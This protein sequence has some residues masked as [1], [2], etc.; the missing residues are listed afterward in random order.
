MC[1]ITTPL[2]LGTMVVYKLSGRRAVD[3]P[4]DVKRVLGATY[5]C[6]R[7][8]AFCQVAI[9]D[10]FVTSREFQRQYP[11]ALDVEYRPGI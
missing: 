10:C 1:I 4:K 3:A 2:I 9:A 11:T 6:L 8:E 7:V 5:M